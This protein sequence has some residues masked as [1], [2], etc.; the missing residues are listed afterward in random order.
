M[1]ESPKPKQ[2]KSLAPKQLDFPTALAEVILTRHLT[3]LEWN[4]KEIYIA[5]RDGFLMIRVIEDGS[6]HPLLVTDGDMLAKDWVVIR[7]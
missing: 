4:N 6:F 3:R 1:S 2:P 7:E 5:L